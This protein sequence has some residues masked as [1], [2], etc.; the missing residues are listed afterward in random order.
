MKKLVARHIW[1]NNQQVSAFYHDRKPAKAKDP[2]DV[3]QFEIKPGPAS[4]NQDPVRMF[5]NIEDCTAI[6]HCL[7]TACTFAIR[8][9][10]P[11]GPKE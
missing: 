4:A 7:S 6:I 8:D 2:S 1:K 3:I 10:H 9:R 11:V 5:M